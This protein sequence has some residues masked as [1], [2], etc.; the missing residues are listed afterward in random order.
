MNDIASINALLIWPLAVGWSVSISIGR[1]IV[2]CYW[3][4]VAFVA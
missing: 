1:T 3:L 2:R 4:T